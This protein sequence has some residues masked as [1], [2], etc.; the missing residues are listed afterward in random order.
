MLKEQSATPEDRYALAQMYL[1]AGAWAQASGQLRDLVA[2]YGNEPRFVAAYA[3]ALLDHNEAATAELYLERLGKIAPAQFVT[4]DLQAD[5]LF[6]KKEYEKALDLLKSFLENEK[7][8]PSDRGVRMRLVAQKVE[9]L[10]HRLTES[11]QKP[12]ADRYN[13]QAEMFYRGYVDQNKGQEL[14]LIAFLGRQGRVDDALE[15]LDRTWQDSNP[16][17]LAQV[18]S[19]LLRDG[20]AG[21]EQMQRL[22]RI[23]QAA[24]KLFERPV[25]LLLMM[26]D[27]RTTQSRYAE[28]EGF[29]REVLQKNSG[30][31]VAM[32]NLAV[33]LALQGIKLDESLKFIN[34]AIEIAGPVAAMLDSRATVRMAVGEPDKALEDMAEAL[35]DAETPVRLFHQAQAYEKAGQPNAAAAVMEKAVQKGLTKSMLQ[36]LELPAFEKLRQLPR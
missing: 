9:Q 12:T 24:L 1:A 2:S 35:N 17:V 23:L 15:L 18:S 7:S 26:A 4:A 13:Q 36:P 11:A 20:K 30:N 14:L 10:G 33:L 32:N 31:A 6:R 28:A 29:Y 8:Q 21:K 22:D 25:P 3:K 27:I 16:A 5:A 34:Q 19:I